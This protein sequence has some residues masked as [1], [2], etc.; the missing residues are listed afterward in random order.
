MTFHRRPMMFGCYLLGQFI[1]FSLSASSCTRSLSPILIVIVWVSLLHCHII[2][3][4]LQSIAVRRAFAW[5]YVSIACHY[6][7]QRN[8]FDTVPDAMQIRFNN[9]L[10][11]A[12][13]T[14]RAH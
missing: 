6:E 12:K 1:I 9:I 2:I 7:Y 3:I 10:A 11:V 13:T 8:P 5:L 14:T 4:S